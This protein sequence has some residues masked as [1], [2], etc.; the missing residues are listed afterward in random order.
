MESAGDADDNDESLLAIS[1]RDKSITIWSSKTGRQVACLRLPGANGK[2]KQDQKMSWT[3]C[4]W[5]KRDVL[6][7]SGIHG[8]LLEWNLDKITKRTQDGLYRAEGHAEL[9]VVHRE[10]ARTLYSIHTTGASIQS[11]GQDRSIVSFHWESHS[12]D[13]HLPAFAAKVYSIVPNCLDP[14]VIAISA[15]DAQIRVWKMK[16][17]KALFDVNTIWQKLNGA[18][19]T[20]LAWHPDKDNIL[21][22]GTD[23]G[24]VGLLDAFSNRSIPT[25]C[26]YKHRSTVYNLCFGPAVGN[27]VK[28][29]SSGDDSHSR[30]MLYSCGDGAVMMHSTKQ[31]GSKTVNVDDVINETNGLARKQPNRSDVMFQPEEF[32]FMVLGSDDGMIEVLN[33]P[34]LEIVCVL[35]SFQKLVQS[36]AWHPKFIGSSSEPSAYKNWIATASNEVDIHVWD[37]TSPLESTQVVSGGCLDVSD[38]DN[39]NG[40][41]NTEKG[42]A[43][44]A[45][46]PILTEPTSVLSGHHLRVICLNWSPHENAKLLSVSYDCTAQVSG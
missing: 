3:T 40:S 45:A 44:A 34:R 21:A 26:D 18:K 46:W 8:E 19:I 32:K 20:T 14:S 12:L 36:L 2:A 31:E 10:H 23:E 37:L 29:L 30:K 9:Q 4:F 24:R 39:L 33:V 38:V 17:N 28:S 25:F 6:L 41:I 43:A 1:S 7:S 35:K 42:D 16:S 13:F 5:W 27:K 15:G 11:S 22:F